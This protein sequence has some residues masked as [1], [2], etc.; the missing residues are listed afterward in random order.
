MN[1]RRKSSVK[2]STRKPPGEVVDG[3]TSANARRAKSSKVVQFATPDSVLDVLL[4]SPMPIQSAD[5]S[6]QEEATTRKVEE[7][8]KELG[9]LECEVISA[10]FPSNGLPESFESIALRLGMTVKEVRDLAD[11]ALR[12]LRGT[13]GAPSRASSIWN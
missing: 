2:S 11:N 1:P 10:L 6:T 4:E 12:G 9:K 13:K 3:F 7:A 8:K 5:T